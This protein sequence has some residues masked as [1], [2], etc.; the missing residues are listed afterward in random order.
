MNHAA[1]MCETFSDVKL[2]Y[3]Q[4]VD[5]TTVN[6]CCVFRNIVLSRVVELL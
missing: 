6:Y 1:L 5:V 4:T 3:R 2:H